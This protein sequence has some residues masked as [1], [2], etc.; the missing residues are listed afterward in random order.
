MRQKHKKSPASGLKNAPDS[1]AVHPRAH[2]L[3]TLKKT[4]FWRLFPPT[5]CVL[6][7]R[8]PPAARTSFKA[9]PRLFPPPR[10][11]ISFPSISAAPTPSSIKKGATPPLG[12]PQ[13]KLFKISSVNPF[14]AA[15]SL[16]IGVYAE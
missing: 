16:A 13:G 1:P 8:Q 3:K 15:L 4:L 10:R 5:G 9:A 14:P 7:A 6:L 11:Q 12:S 2:F